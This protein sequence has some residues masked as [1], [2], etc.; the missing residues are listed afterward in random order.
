MNLDELNEVMDQVTYKPGW[1]FEL[2]HCGLGVILTMRAWVPDST[3]P[4]HRPV[5]IV[6]RRPIDLLSLSRLDEAG[7]LDWLLCRVMSLESHET[8]EWFRYRGELVDDPHAG[9]KIRATER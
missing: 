4:E 3:T 6:S 7:F 5:E 1:T 2:G 8:R 9:E